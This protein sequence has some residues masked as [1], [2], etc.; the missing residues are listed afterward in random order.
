VSCSAV[1]GLDTPRCGVLWLKQAGLLAYTASS[2]L[3]LFD[4][5]TKQQSL[6]S[7]HRR[8]I[9]ALAVSQDGTL[10]A[11]G[12]ATA[13]PAGGYADA[14]L[15]DVGTRCLVALLQ[16]HA[17]CVEALAFSPD[18]AW[19]ASAGAGRVVVWDIAAGK[20]AAVGAVKQVR[21]LHCHL[22]QLLSLP[23][24]QTCAVCIATHSPRP[25]LR[26]LITCWSLCCCCQPQIVSDIAWLPHTRLPA[27]VTIIYPLLGMHRL[28]QT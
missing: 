1:L 10:V 26:T 15:W 22:D 14:A 27:F 23:F 4:L 7:H 18:G 28:P 13:E 19:L 2:T 11:T 20:A 16:Q 3:I 24:L 25:G 12:S 8:P 9:G 17:V 6:L 21:S 5:A